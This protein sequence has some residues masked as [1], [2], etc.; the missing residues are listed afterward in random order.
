MELLDSLFKRRRQQEEEEKKKKTLKRR[1][2][3]D[4]ENTGIRR[5]R[6]SR[7]ENRA[8]GERER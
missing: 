1:K 4:E 8:A 2:P 7:S 6:K 3:V 5:M